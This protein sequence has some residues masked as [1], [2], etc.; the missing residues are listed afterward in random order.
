[1]RNSLL[2]LLLTLSV[3]VFA[4][5]SNVV[6]VKNADDFPKPNA[7]KEITLNP[8]K[9]YL[10][11]GRIDLGDRH[12]NL[13]GAS[14]QGMDPG[15]DG[16]I[17]ACEGGV[18]RSRSNNVY[19]EKISVMCAGPKTMGYDFR[20]D[21]QSSYCNLFQG[22]S[23]LEAPGMT[24]KGVGRIKGF[25]TTCIDLNYWHTKKGLNVGG[26]MAKLTMVYNYITG[27]QAD[28]AIEFEKDLIAK[29]IVMAGN[30]FVYGGSDGIKVQK[31]AVIGQGRMVSNL[32]QGQENITVGFGPDTPGW[33][34]VTNSGKISDSR[35]RA[36][37]YMNDNETN[38]EFIQP[39]FRK[40]EGATKTSQLKKFSNVQDNRLRY[41]GMK[42]IVVD[43][44]ITLSGISSYNSGNYSVALMKNG[45]DLIFPKATA[46][47]ID[48]G[49]SF[50]LSLDT[51]A[52]LST[53]DYIE[54][55]LKADNNP[56]NKPV[57]VKDMI[58]K[59]VQ[60]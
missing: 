32:F 6:N 22:C 58:V 36:A 27:I 13:N 46:Y 48:A 47:N 15:K 37:I 43:V 7:Q 1:M 57:L 53:D 50:N 28:A 26:K 21:T 11:H 19:L 5:K 51:Q 56:N 41:I 34:M 18:L 38:T 4:Q 9:V 12:I 49:K 8:D 55:V 59:V 25:N 29:D 17:S 14:L 33:E 20:D 40:V 44:V 39:V 10:V 30:Y 52:K 3:S 31:G 42:D 54:V 60:Y 45:E 2:L 16:L 24:S 23:V 35:A